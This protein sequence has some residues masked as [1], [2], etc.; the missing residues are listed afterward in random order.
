MTLRYPY[1]VRQPEEY[2]SDIPD[3][4]MP[5]DMLKLAEHIVESKED[6]FRPHE[7]V[8]HYEVAVV[9]MLK[10]KQAGVPVKPGRSRIA[11]SKVINL[12]DALRKS[13]AG[14]EDHGRQGLRAS[15]QL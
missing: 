15:S 4:K 10:K 5:A 14:G 2:F 13:A 9:D 11:S 7:F 6:D 12:M 8:D 1:E 3:V